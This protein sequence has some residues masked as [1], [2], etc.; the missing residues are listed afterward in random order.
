MDV[1]QATPANALMQSIMRALARG[2]GRS[3]VQRAARLGRVHGCPAPNRHLIVGAKRF[4][5][6]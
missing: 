1:S 6:C 4:V 3:A 5:L 2:A